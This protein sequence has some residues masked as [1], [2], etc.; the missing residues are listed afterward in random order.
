MAHSPVQSGL[1]GM[2]VGRSRAAAGRR[3]ERCAG[4]GGSG[5]LGG[6]NTVLPLPPPRR[7]FRGRAGPSRGAPAPPGRP[8]PA[9]RSRAWGGGEGPGAA[10][11]RRLSLA[12]S[13]GGQGGMRGAGGVRTTAPSPLPSAPSASER[14]AQR[15]PSPGQE[16]GGKCLRRPPARSLGPA[17]RR[18]RGVAEAP[19]LPA[20]PAV[21]LRREG[22]RGA[23]GPVR[24]SRAAEEGGVEEGVSCQPHF[25]RVCSARFLSVQTQGKVRDREPGTS[26]TRC[27][28]VS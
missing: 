23:P 17:R 10:A 19:S 12:R 7:P 26:G 28:R 1:P 27:T 25:Q 22:H 14:Q 11:W 8:C 5:E 15:G 4:R 18:G 21:K 2:Q 16:G 20:E 9:P 6:V 3:G 13:R 24:A